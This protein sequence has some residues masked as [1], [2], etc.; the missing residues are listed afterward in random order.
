MVREPLMSGFPPPAESRVTLANWQDP[1]YNRWSFQHL[2]ELIPTQRISRG[3]PPWHSSANRA[4]SSVLED[5]TVHRLAGHASTFN[6]VIAETW[7]D[8]CGA[9]PGSDRVRAVFRRHDR[10]DPPSVDVDHEIRCRLHRGNLVE[11]GLLDT[12]SRPAP[13]SL[14]SSGRGMTV[15]LSVSYWICAQGRIPRGVHQ[16]GRRGPGDG[17]IHGVAAR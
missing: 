15:R 9:A 7:T 11:Q 14:R 6:E 10:G 1:P 16:P 12:D 13:T 5:V 2:R 3:H 8:G 4:A 17:A